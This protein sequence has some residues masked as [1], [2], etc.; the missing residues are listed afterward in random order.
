MNLH[1]IIKTILLSMLPV[2]ELRA[3]LPIA[4]KTMNMPWYYAYLFSVVGNLVPVPFILLFMDKAVKWL[5]VIPFMKKFFDYIFVR[6]RKRSKIIETLEFYGLIV[7]VAIPLPVT[8]AWTGALAAYLFGIKF[9]KA[10]LG[11]AIGVSIAGI[12][13]LTLTLLGWTGAIIAITVLLIW[14]IISI[15]KGIKK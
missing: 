12:I 4:I 7:F 13:V 1:D 10:I 8:G 5:S 2:G 3:A 14:A 11:I 6:T 15:Y 9:Y